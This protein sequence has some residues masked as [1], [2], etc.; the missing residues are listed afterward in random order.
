MI[1]LNQHFFKSQK[2][3]NRPVIQPIPFTKEEFAKIKAEFESLA[4]LR[5]EVL[6]RLQT[7]REMGDLS[8]NGAY[9]YAKFELADIGRKQRKLNYLIANGFVQEKT[10]TDK[11][12]F[13][14]QVTISNGQEEKTY[15]IVSEHESNP[16]ENKLSLTSPIGSSLIDKKIGDEI[17]VITPKGEA[18]YQ[19]INVT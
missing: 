14:S 4:Q 7:A 8:E 19:I 13:G 9:K 3:I 15:L 1:N 16:K 6:V 5:K 2:Q 12:G 10:P 11:I 18:V 17:K